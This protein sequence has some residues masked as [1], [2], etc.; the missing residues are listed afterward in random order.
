MHFK[1]ISKET[2]YNKTALGFVRKAPN[3]NRMG[4]KLMIT[5]V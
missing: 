1:E 2:M 3:N 5:N 4:F